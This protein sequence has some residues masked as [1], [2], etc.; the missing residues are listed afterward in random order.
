LDQQNNDEKNKRRFMQ[1]TLSLFREEPAIG[2]R[3][4][5]LKDSNN[6]FCDKQT[7]ADRAPTM[8]ELEEAL[9][10]TFGKEALEVVWGLVREETGSP[11]TQAPSSLPT[12]IPSESPSECT[13]VISKKFTSQIFIYQIGVAIAAA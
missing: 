12:S 10:C 6:C 3:R 7:I 4:R 1:S 2:S 9:E 11:E 13:A 5:G 8:I